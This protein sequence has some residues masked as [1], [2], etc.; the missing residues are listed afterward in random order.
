M[1]DGNSND[2]GGHDA[3]RADW[4]Q[5]PNPNDPDFETKAG[6]V[7]ERL[8]RPRDAKGYRFTDPKDF[9]L[10]DVDKEYRE[11]FRGVAHRAHLTQRQVNILQDWQVSNAKLM[12]DAQKAAR[13]GA[14][15]AAR[16]ALEK[17]FGPSYGDRVKG[18]YEN[19]RQMGI[20]KLANA[21]LQD[22]SRLGDKLEFVRAMV[23]LSNQREKAATASA[24]H[25]SGA[26]DGDS[27]EGGEIDEQIQAIQESAMKQGLD[28]T[29]RHWPHRQLE[30]L[31]KERYGSEPLSNAYGSTVNAR[32][33]RK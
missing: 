12:R 15:K 21:T 23:A 24:Y 13:E 19:M 7:Y 16:A 8:G 22:G 25:A 20:D 6:V 31:Y 14:P 26:G 28:P 32:H 18:A 1:Q 4:M 33:R 29:H 9:Q 3:A 27:G 30:R 17:E 11:S 2:G 10:D 5:I